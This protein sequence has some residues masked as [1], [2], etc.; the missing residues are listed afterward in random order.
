MR[1]TEERAR[2]GGAK[3]GSAERCGRRR[4]RRPA[5]LFAGSGSGY[6]VQGVEKVEGVAERGSRGYEWLPTSF[7]RPVER[8]IAART[9][10]EAGRTRLRGASACGAAD[11]VWKGLHGSLRFDSF[12]S[13]EHPPPTL[14]TTMRGTYCSLPPHL[15]AARV[16]SAP[17][18]P[19]DPRQRP[20]EEGLAPL[21][22]PPVAPP[23]RRPRARR[24]PAP[25]LPPPIDARAAPQQHSPPTGPAFGPELNSL[26]TPV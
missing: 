19:I 4:R 20:A 2:K 11:G 9:E 14:T 18:P 16:S 22:G 6:A 8:V 10:A 13:P 25:L 26:R 17:P 23:P 3:C 7:P 12:S 5:V 15:L 24:T 1:R 21:S